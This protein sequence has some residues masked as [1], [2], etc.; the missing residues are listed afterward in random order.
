MVHNCA[1]HANGH[2]LGRIRGLGIGGIYSSSNIWLRWRSQPPGDANGALRKIYD[3]SER[4]AQLPLSV[5]LALGSGTDLVSSILGLVSYIL[6]PTSR[7][8]SSD[9]LTD[10]SA[11][12]FGIQSTRN[13]LPSISVAFCG[14][15]VVL[16]CACT[17][18]YMYIRIYIYLYFFFLGSAFYAFYYRANCNLSDAS[19]KII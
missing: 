8:R 11:A 15:C 1:S 14:L 16:L 19:R 6:Y 9:C 4:T 7:S 12:T 13:S 17:K 18:I 5:A 10:G 2:C 3:A